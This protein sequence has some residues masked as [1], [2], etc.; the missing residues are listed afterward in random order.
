M[1][2]TKLITAEE[3]RQMRDMSLIHFINN[4]MDKYIKHINQ[5]VREETAKGKWDFSVAMKYSPTFPDLVS[6]KLLGELSE[7][8]RKV[9]I[10][11]LKENGYTAIEYCDAFYLSWAIPQEKPEPVKEEPKKKSLWDIVWDW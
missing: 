11:H 8:Q 3:A 7:E 5:I 4:D 1:M 10:N 9:I 6:D 2:V